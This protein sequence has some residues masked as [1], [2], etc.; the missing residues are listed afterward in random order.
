MSWN[1]LKWVK[2]R[3]VRSCGK[4]INIAY[5]KHAHNLYTPCDYNT[6]VSYRFLIADNFW[7]VLSQGHLFYGAG[8]VWFRKRVKIITI[9]IYIQLIFTVFTQS[10]NRPFAWN[11]ANVAKRTDGPQNMV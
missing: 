4:N 1:Y 2:Q 5:C 6:H 9:L 7:L 8:E 3:K 10:H 11:I